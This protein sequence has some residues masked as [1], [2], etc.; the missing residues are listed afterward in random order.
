MFFSKAI[1]Y[2]VRALP[3]A[4]LGLTFASSYGPMAA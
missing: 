4:R 3:S 1:S 2:P